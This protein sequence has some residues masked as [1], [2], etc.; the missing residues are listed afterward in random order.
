MASFH[1]KDSEP[2]DN[3]SSKLYYPNSGNPLDELLNLCKDDNNYQKVKDFVRAN[4]S[5]SGHGNDKTRY[6]IKLNINNKSNSGETV[7][8][9]ACSFGAKDIAKYLISL[10]ADVNKFNKTD[11][12]TALSW[13]SEYGHQKV[14]R[15]LLDANAEVD[16]AYV[17]FSGNTPLMQACIRGHAKCV[18][19]LLQANAA[20]DKVNNW[21]RTPLVAAI[22]HG[23]IE[24][25]R[26]LLKWS[27]DVDK[28]VDGQ[29]PL[30]IAEG[31]YPIVEELVK[32]NADVNKVDKL[33]NTALILACIY[34]CL[35]TIRGRH[36]SI[37]GEKDCKKV[38]E[39][40][41]FGSGANLDIF[42][43]DGMDAISMAED[44]GNMEVVDILMEAIEAQG[45]GHIGNDED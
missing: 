38:V 7:L 44:K 16:K 28:L 42:N 11:G 22:D 4:G 37:G 8:M 30:M 12:K 20:V 13:A 29:T 18:E 21:G 15:L 3:T 32:H 27:A 36:C 43:N 45:G 34:N 25:V 17:Y 19:M 9:V 5:M 2:L 39:I 24:V 40:L 23:H 14:V 6:K 10:E 31:R 26:L 41:A 35:V 1:E 33:G